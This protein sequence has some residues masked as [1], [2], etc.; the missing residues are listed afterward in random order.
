MSRAD[1]LRE[2][3]NEELYERLDDAKEELFNLRFQK[4]VGQLEDSSRPSLVKR[5]VA[6]IK[7]LIR[8]RELGI[9]A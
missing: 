8:E 2:L 4:Q 7:T 3:T 1:E 9:N 6:R 5:Q